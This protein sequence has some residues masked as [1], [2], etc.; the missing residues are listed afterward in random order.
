MEMPSTLPPP[1][2]VRFTSLYQP[3]MP[4]LAESLIPFGRWSEEHIAA[5]L[6]VAV[7]YPAEI[8]QRLKVLEGYI[9]PGGWPPQVSSDAIGT[10]R[11]IVK[12]M[13]PQVEA[14]IAQGVRLTAAAA[15]RDDGSRAVAVRDQVLSTFLASKMLATARALRS[16]MLVGE[17]TLDWGSEFHEM[18]GVFS[19]R[20]IYGLSFLTREPHGWAG[21]TD[22]DLWVDDRRYRLFAPICPEPGATIKAKTLSPEDVQRLIIPQVLCP[23]MYGQSSFS[24]IQRLAF[25]AW[26]TLKPGLILRDG[27][28]VD[29]ET[30]SDHQHARAYITRIMADR[31]VSRLQQIPPKGRWQ[32]FL[33]MTISLDSVS[34]EVA[35]QVREKV[36]FD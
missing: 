14:D 9:A 23:E 32:L 34:N 12:Q 26:A 35:D 29:A 30:C 4:A 16:Y 5:H 22:A 27:V 15:T 7:S 20:L 28:F 17:P 1:V 3:D 8:S 21:W 25:E 18:A 11:A 13:M 10:I 33:K 24:T 31:I 2:Q 36:P 19:D 6:P